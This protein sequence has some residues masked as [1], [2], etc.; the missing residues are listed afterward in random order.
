MIEEL[1]RCGLSHNEA[2]IY[3]TC[4][5]LGR[6]PSAQIIER[7]SLPRGTVYD[8]L[9]AI[10]KMG[11]VSSCKINSRLHFTPNDP[12]CLMTALEDRR[13]AVA[14]ILPALKQARG[15]ATDGLT[16]ETFRGSQSIRKLLSGMLEHTNELSVI[17][18]L[19]SA[20]I[21]AEY[22]IR[23]FTTKRLKNKVALRQITGNG[24]EAQFNQD[25]SLTAIRYL[26]TFHPM[27]E[28]TL[29]TD[30]AVISVLMQ[31]PCAFVIRAPEHR[32]TMRAVFEFFWRT[33]SDLDG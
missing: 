15:T 6:A 32:K 27:K 23:N 16:V 14:G 5:Q 3:L 26:A 9:N 10:E 21:V 11:L 2:N 17:G 22:P 18:S 8:V 1:M 29:I 25:D 19:Q 30:D 33:T 12:E 13:D 20:L 7:S 28:I 4:L 31:E 24:A